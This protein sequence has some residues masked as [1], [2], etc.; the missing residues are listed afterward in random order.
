[1]T[2]MF[3][4]PCQ[5]AGVEIRTD[6][7]AVPSVEIQTDRQ[8]QT[9]RHRHTQTDTHRQTHT[10]FKASTFQLNTL[11]PVIFCLICLLLKQLIRQKKLQNYTVVNL[12]NSISYVYK[13]IDLRTSLCIIYL[14][15]PSLHPHECSIQFHFVSLGKEGEGDSLMFAS[16]PE[17]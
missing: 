6:M 12:A 2:M 10:Y 9:H 3:S 1:M 11:S 17:A 5:T 8:R 14:F 15:R 4:E 16:L 13:Q 7:S